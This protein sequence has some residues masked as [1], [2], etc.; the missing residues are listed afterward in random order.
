MNSMNRTYVRRWLIPLAL[1]AGASAA[2]SSCSDPSLVGVTTAPMLAAQKV[3][4]GRL[5]SCPPASYDSVTQVIGPAGGLL[6]VGGHVLVV[7]SLALTSPVSITAVAPSQS[8]NLVRF[9]PEGLKFKP[10]VHGI[11]A[12]VATNLDNCGVHP[13]QVL[14]IVHV[15]DSLSIL[16]Y[17]QSP[18]STDSAVVVKYKTYLGSLWVG[19]LLHHFSNYA[20]AW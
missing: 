19:G 5:L 3:G 17:L 7:D 10:G 18:T 4:G 12:L 2:A 20:V 11:G 1:L 6:V 16:G 13:N 9:R 15:D 14:Q 8:V